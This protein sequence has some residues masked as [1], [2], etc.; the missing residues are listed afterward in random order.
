MECPFCYTNFEYR[1]S[2]CPHCGKA[3][4]DPIYQELFS[5]VKPR[6]VEAAAPVIQPEQAFTAEPIVS[7]PAFEAPMA[8]PAIL[9]EEI[10]DKP[11]VTTEIKS[12]D[13]CN[14][15]L[16]FPGKK[17]ELP[18]WRLELQSRLKEIKDQRA[19]AEPASEALV[20]T[21]H[22]VG[23]T[24]L[25]ALFSRWLVSPGSWNGLRGCR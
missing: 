16:D 19:Q 17:V 14:T 23:G 24:G 2:I 18:E 5:R 6:K 8:P 21:K 13:T 3:T 7:R 25:V 10:R 9:A 12:K 1:L 20:A 15:L 4:D 22:A 11:A